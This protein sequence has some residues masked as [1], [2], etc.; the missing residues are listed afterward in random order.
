MCTEPKI[1][2]PRK[3]DSTEELGPSSHLLAVKVTWI[4][5]ELG[6][7]G[8]GGL[9]STGALQRSCTYY[10]W[11]CQETKPDVALLP[12]AEDQPPNPTEGV[13]LAQDNGSSPP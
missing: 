13:E 11:Y 9:F 8:E 3:A 10:A 4:T 12:N 2:F 7:G 1:K 6:S 5:Q